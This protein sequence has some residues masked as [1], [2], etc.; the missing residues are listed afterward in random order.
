MKKVI[1]GKTGIEVTEL[2]FGALPIGPAQKNVPVAEAAEVMALGLKSGITFFDTAQMYKTYEPLKIAMEKTGIRPVISTKSVAETYE[3]MD[4]AVREALEKLG[5]DY[6]DIFF[7]HAAR[8]NPDVFT[9]RKE[10]IKCLLDYKKKGVIKAVGISAHAT[11]VVSA[12]AE[13]PDID[14]VF[15][16]LNKTGMGIL[17]GNLDDMEKAV[18]KCFENN[19]GVMLMK[20]L[21]G[22]NLLSD[23]ASAM[24]YARNFAKNRAP[25]AL[26]MV[27]QD[28]VVSNVKY[29][30]GGDITEELSR[31]KDTV[32]YMLVAKGLC[33]TCGKCV[34][35]CHS[36]AVS[37]VEGSAA[38]DAKNCL[39]CG[40]CVAA[41]PE[42]AIRVV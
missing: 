35:A 9:R 26:G 36:A 10:A 1:L 24:E 16:I 6:I 31:V 42:F 23:Y 17:N 13:N 2:C 27:A 18:N 12:A 20:A 29:F 5:V 19:K 14:V 33:K 38:I 4:F 30:S 37:I 7:I 8:V 3:D 11:D 21:A 39:K 40:Y 22:G 15:A 25:I 28:E 32:K 41:C 34:E